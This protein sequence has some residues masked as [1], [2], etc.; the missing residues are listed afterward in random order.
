MRPNS[1]LNEFCWG[2]LL[3]HTGALFCFV[4]LIMLLR[5]SP[6][7]VAVKELLPGA[8]RQGQPLHTLAGFALGYV[9]MWVTA[10]LGA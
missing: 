5:F 6:Q 1:G 4:V 10:E 7:A 8:W 2:G 9:V 3:S